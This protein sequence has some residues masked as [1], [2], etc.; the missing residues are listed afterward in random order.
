MTDEVRL[1]GN[2]TERDRMEFIEA[3]R[4]MGT[5]G[6]VILDESNPVDFIGL[7]GISLHHE[8][9]DNK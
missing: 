5:A 4:E 1:H 3:L 6:Y 9:P 2:P 8:N 7:G